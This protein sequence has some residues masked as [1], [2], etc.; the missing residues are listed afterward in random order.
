M[1]LIVS[2]NNIRENY[3]VG[4]ELLQHIGNLEKSR[5]GNVLVSPWPVMSIYRTPC[6]RVLLNPIRDANPFFHFMEGIWMMSGSMNGAFLNYFV[7]DFTQRF[8]D[9]GTMLHGA[10]GY[11]WRYH[12]DF[13]QVDEA[14]RILRSNFSDRRAVIAMWDPRADLNYNSKDIP[15]N[16]HIY[17]RVRDQS[18]LDM[19]INCRSNDII[20]GAYGA[21]G[22][23]F[24]MLQE[25]MSAMIGL[26][27]GRLYQ[28]SWN[29]HAYT[30]VFDKLIDGVNDGTW[31]APYNGYMPLCSNPGTFWEECSLFVHDEQKICSYRNRVFDTVA[32]PM[33]KAYGMYRSK[34][35]DKALE[36]CDTIEAGDWRQ[37]CVEWITRRKIK[38]EFRESNPE[39]APAGD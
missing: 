16:T 13:D 30:S 23:H 2:G 39:P 19:M 26:K 32:F 24:S 34:M 18:C 31:M 5:A 9:K 38:H 3:K 8:A 36:V 22:V 37:A 14:I 11:R 21:N 17:L 10:Y 25:Y 6:H 27:V 1:S 7:A 20:W 33:R 35:F 15:C 28:N 29:F 4:M 12:F